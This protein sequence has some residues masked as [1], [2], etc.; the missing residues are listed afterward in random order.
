[1]LGFT[2]T[3]I[4]TRQFKDLR[5]GDRFWYERDDHQI[6]FT[7]GQLAEL[8]KCTLARVICDNTDGVTRIHEKVF[9]RPSSTLNPA[10]DC[11]DVPFVNLN[12]FREGKCCFLF[13]TVQFRGVIES[14]YSPTQPTNSAT[15]Q[16][17]NQ[18]INQSINQPINQ[19]INQ[20]ID[21]AVSLNLKS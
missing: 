12:V 8:R 18:S 13:V 10:I 6:G 20:S 3:C 2:F 4:M 1:M 19:S 17:T 14:N 15:N 21:R 11:D 5:F 16:P 7:K 9:R